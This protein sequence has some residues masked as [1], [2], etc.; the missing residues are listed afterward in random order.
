MTT[1]SRRAFKESSGVNAGYID[2]TGMKCQEDPGMHLGLPKMLAPPADAV[3]WHDRDERCYFMCWPCTDHNVRN[4][5]GFIVASG[6]FT[7][8]WMLF[9]RQAQ[10]RAQRNAPKAGIDG[11]RKVSDGN[12]PPEEMRHGKRTMV[13]YWQPD[14]SAP[15]QTIIRSVHQNAAR[16]REGAL[17]K[18]LETAPKPLLVR[19]T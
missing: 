9:R 13:W 1:G 4:R 3:V 15:I 19:Y 16:G 18:P 10:R 5:G 8:P 7:G 14:L 6:N 11:W 17:W 2:L 12:L